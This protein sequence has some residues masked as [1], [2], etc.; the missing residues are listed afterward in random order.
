MSDLAF[1]S[2]DQPMTNGVKY[3]EECQRYKQKCLQHLHRAELSHVLALRQV[4]F[5]AAFQPE[6][7]RLILEARGGSAGDVGDT[8]ASIITRSHFL[9]LKVEFEFFFSRLL[10]CVW[11]HHFTALLRQARP[12]LLAEAHKLAEFARAVAR[13]DAKGFV[14]RKL[15]PRHGLE[16]MCS[17][18]KDSTGIDAPSCL[19]S[20]ERRH[21]SQIRSAFEVRHLFEHANGRVD[22]AFLERVEEGS[23]L[24]FAWRQSTWGGLP[25]GRNAKVPIRGED[26]EAT[27][28]AML[29]AA[30]RIGDEVTNFTPQPESR[31]RQGTA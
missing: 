22:D 15:I 18:L 27:L 7:E 1:F 26:F 13:D 30:R 25:L 2:E 17:V 6:D 28:E 19:S 11:D 16:K 29:L 9:L 8:V 5:E 3:S 23:S 10:H 4:R 31:R 12:K 24:G 20:E 21:R 14:L